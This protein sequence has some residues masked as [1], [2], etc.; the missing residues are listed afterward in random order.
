MVNNITYERY[1]MA[2]Q[3]LETCCNDTSLYQN[4]N[5]R[6]I[7]GIDDPDTEH[8]YDN[9]NKDAKLCPVI[10]DNSLNEHQKLAVKNCLNANN[11]SCIH[12]PPGTG[13]TKTVIEIIRQLAKKGK[14]IL[15]SA[16]SNMAVDNLVE[17]L[18][19]FKDGFNI[20]RIG[21]PGRMMKSLQEYCLDF[22]INLETKKSIE[23]KDL[24]KT[25]KK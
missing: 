19:K 6:V 12:G 9:T 17:R 16:A 13:K 2:L 20:I 23:I 3:R 18:V 24:K 8:P 11:F 4:H 25:M 22:F 15:V 1:S 14:K 7:F 5:L 21:Q 10:I